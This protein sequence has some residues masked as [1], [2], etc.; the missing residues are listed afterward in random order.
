MAGKSKS[1]KK[2]K[3]IETQHQPQMKIVAVDACIACPT[4]CSRGIQYM[5]KMQQPGAI[6][7]GIPCILTLK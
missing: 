3:G 6:G 2:K 1:A 5:E 4:R 7:Y